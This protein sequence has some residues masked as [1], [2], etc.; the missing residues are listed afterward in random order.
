[1]PNWLIII[2]LGLNQQACDQQKTRPSIGLR[3]KHR[4]VWSTNVFS[5][6]LPAPAFPPSYPFLLGQTHINFSNSP[7]RFLV[8]P[9]RETARPASFVN[10]ARRSKKLLAGETEK[11]RRRFPTQVV[12]V[13][14]PQQVQ[15]ILHLCQKMIDIGF[16]FWTVAKFL[17]LGRAVKK[18]GP[19]C[20]PTTKAMDTSKD[21]YTKN[22]ARG[23]TDPGYFTL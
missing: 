22:I 12:V 18:R 8:L 21:R 7:N 3:K 6:S 13:V 9:T 14:H 11:L 15:R 1:M 19:F 16:E 4:P 10:P 2:K 20:R 17:D 23:T 5:F